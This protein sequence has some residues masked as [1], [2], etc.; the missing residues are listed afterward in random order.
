MLSFAGGMRDTIN[1]TRGI[2]DQITIGGSLMCSLLGKMGDN[3]DESKEDRMSSDM[4]SI[5]E[6]ERV[7]FSW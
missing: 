2:R 3:I 1:F 7:P 4:T 6:T 5:A